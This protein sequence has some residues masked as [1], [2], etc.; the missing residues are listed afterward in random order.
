MY[1]FITTGWW[2]F[3]PLSTKCRILSTSPGPLSTSKKPFLLLLHHFPNG[4]KSV[5]RAINGLCTW[6]RKGAK[7]PV[8]Q[9]SSFSNFRLKGFH[10]WSNLGLTA[11]V[12]EDWSLES[13]QVVL[14]SSANHISNLQEKSR[15]FWQFWSLPAEVGIVGGER[16]SQQKR[17]QTRCV[18]IGK[19]SMKPNIVWEATR[20]RSICFSSDTITV[21]AI[22]HPPNLCPLAEFG[23]ST[24]LCLTLVESSCLIY[25][26]LPIRER[27]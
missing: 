1:R 24:V 6:L 18:W 27:V 14:F 19:W 12:L 9:Y 2:W 15:V 20:A 23:K 25:R 13:G 17:L 21:G 22:H 7:C 16:V 10:T 26:A 8:G 3:L 5:R 4:K 11:L